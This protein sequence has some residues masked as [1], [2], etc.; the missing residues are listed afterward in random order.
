[1]SENPVEEQRR[2]GIHVEETEYSIAPAGNTSIDVTLR[3]NGLED[4]TFA[5]T[6]GGIS[7]SWISTATP[8]VTLEPGEE[9]EITL[10]I[11]APPLTESS[12]GQHPVKIR[13]TSKKVPN[14][15][16]EIELTLTVAALEVQGRIGLLMDSLQFTVAPGSGAT[17]SSE[18]DSSRRVWIFSSSPASAL[19]LLFSF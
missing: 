12:V 3:N 17:F 14:Q 19:T 6:V 9:K 11:Q 2:I 8:T 13:A 16:A 15:Y 7:A 4:D 10:I 18:D 1:M 5:L